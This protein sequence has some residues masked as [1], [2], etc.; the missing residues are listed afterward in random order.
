[1]YRR[2]PVRVNVAMNVFFFR[3]LEND[4]L[5]RLPDTEPRNRGTPNRGMSEERAGK[6]V[7]T[8]DAP[9][10]TGACSGLDRRDQGID[11]LEGWEAAEISIR[12]WV[13]YSVR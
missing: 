3:R 1:M 2:A 11:A 7:R 6:T 12:A 9:R 8:F 13:E 5:L 10:N 4:R